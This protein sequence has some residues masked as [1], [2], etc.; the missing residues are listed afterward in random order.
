MD[1]EIRQF[2]NELTRDPPREKKKTLIEDE[3][4]KRQ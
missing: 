4:E 3:E 1:P 2:L